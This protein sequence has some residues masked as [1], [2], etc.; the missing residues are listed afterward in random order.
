MFTIFSLFPFDNLSIVNDS[1][2]SV[3]MD[4]SLVQQTVSMMNKYFTYM[5]KTLHTG[6]KLNEVMGQKDR[7]QVSVLSL[8]SRSVML[9]LLVDCEQLKYTN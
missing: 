5:S 1:N 3:S 7:L 9:I 2:A 8:L 6:V 4:S